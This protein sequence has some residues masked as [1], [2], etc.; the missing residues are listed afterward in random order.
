MS[1]DNFNFHNNLLND[2]FIDIELSD[3]QINSPEFIGGMNIITECYCNCVALENIQNGGG[4]DKMDQEASNILKRLF[5]KNIK[6]N[7]TRYFRSIIRTSGGISADIIT[8]GA[9]G[10]V[11]VNSLFAISESHSFFSQINELI[12]MMYEVKYFF[13]NIIKFDKK[14]TIPFVSRITLDNGLQA[15]ETEFKNK[16]LEF[17]AKFGT[18]HLDKIHETMTNIV[19]KIITLISDWFA[20]LFPNTGGL[21]GEVAYEFLKKI[22]DNSYDYTVRLFA[23]TPKNLRSMVN[24]KYALCDFICKIMVYLRDLLYNL[25]PDEFYDL[26]R[27]IG[28]TVADSVDSSVGKKL[29]EGTSYVTGKYVKYTLQVYDKFGAVT[30]HLPNAMRMMSYIIEKIVLPNVGSGVELFL[31]LLPVYLMSSLFFQ[32]YI[33][34]KNYYLSY[35]QEKKLLENKKEHEEDKEDKKEKN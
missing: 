6:D 23:F 22:A 12:F 20:C 35:V 30:R 24:N 31:Q 14:K 2:N 3:E 7:L 13:G 5:D 11:V 28:S 15:F 17:M 34:M 16:I 8:S 21:A 32:E 9:G 27:I 18:R 33:P 29:A 25:D 10:D 19:D 4:K 26:I 1:H